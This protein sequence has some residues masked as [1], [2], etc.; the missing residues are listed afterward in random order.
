MAPKH[1]S[2]WIPFHSQSCHIEEGE[3]EGGEK[4]EEEAEGSFEVGDPLPTSSPAPA[5][6]CAD[7]CVSTPQEKEMEKQKLL[8]QQSRLHN[9]GAAEMVLQMISACKG[10]I[11]PSPGEGQRGGLTGG[12]QVGG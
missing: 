11:G 5:P 3:E 1:P 9:R 2:L 12:W 10:E 4:D 7:P 6:A 8:Y